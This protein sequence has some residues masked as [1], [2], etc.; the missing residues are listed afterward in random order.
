MAVMERPRWTDERIEERFDRVGTD[1]RSLRME[2]REGFAR[3]EKRFDKVDERFEKI[4][5]RFERVDDKFDSLQAE[6]NRR[7]ESVSRNMIICFVT[8]NATV[9]G[10]LITT[11]L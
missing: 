4:D 3:I 1:I 8:I 2:M 11:Q 7:F 5:K 6:M 9:I 10:A